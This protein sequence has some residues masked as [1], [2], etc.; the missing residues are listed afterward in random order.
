VELR[1]GWQ[2]EEEARAKGHAA[3]A[4][5]DEVGRGALCGP[6]VA[7]AVVL[8]EGFDVEGI[9]DSKRLTCKQREALARRVREGSRACC[10]GIADHREIDRLNILRATYLAMERAVAG[11]TVGPD[12]VLVDAL[13]V[14]GIAAAQQP[15][16]KGDALSVSIAAASIVAKV[17]R[18]ELM[19][20]W[21]RHYPGYGL[22]RNMGYGS[23]LHR[24]ALR[25]MGPT[26]I[27]RRSF[28]GTERWLF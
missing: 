25:Q 24:E 13:T 15:I 18:D 17:A 26:E 20:E 12:L 3:I 22:A 8:G 19:R 7:C 1:C 14:P 23:Q 21:D 5:L 27:H 28:H 2:Y 10:V 9:D 16:V 6:V 4:G 11:L